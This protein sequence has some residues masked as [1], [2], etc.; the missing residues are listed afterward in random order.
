MKNELKVLWFFL[1]SFQILFIIIFS[2]FGYDRNIE[3]SVICKAHDRPNEI[4]KEL[5]Y[6]VPTTIEELQ[7]D[8]YRCRTMLQINQTSF[9]SSSMLSGLNAL[10]CA[11]ALLF[12]IFIE[13]AIF[14][15]L[16]K[17]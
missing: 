8:N 4:K 17:K 15:L 1:F 12:S 6:G 16:V 9:D 10:M 11:V 7:K 5:F 13:A 14:W 3:M 2:W